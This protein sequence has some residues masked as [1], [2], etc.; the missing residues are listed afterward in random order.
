MAYISW[1]T[2]PDNPVTLAGTTITATTENASFPASNLK[3]L[4][5][6]TVW[7]STAIAS[8]Q[9]ID[10]DFGSAKSADL[11]AAVNH[12]VTS[13]A[14]VLQV[15]AGT[16]ASV[17]DFAESITWRE[18]LFFKRLS[19]QQSYRYWRLEILNTLNPDSYIEIGYLLLGSLTSPTFNFQYGWTSGIDFVNLEVA[20]PYG[21]PNVDEKHR[22][23][24]VHMEFG[25]LTDTEM[26]ALRT[27][28]TTVKGAR[29]PLI[30][31]PDREGSDAYFGRIIS[32]FNE[33]IESQRYTSLTFEEDSYG[34]RR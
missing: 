9:N 11:I 26:T 33:R 30:I 29:N 10:I 24:Q 8:Q 1:L 20:S 15:R 6:T 16:T 32:Q 34:N 13:V 27:L 12:N 22:R 3:I 2:H 25:P 19:S 4:P 31:L 17:A 28:Y 21:V 7:R 14:S 18:F 5:T 23:Q